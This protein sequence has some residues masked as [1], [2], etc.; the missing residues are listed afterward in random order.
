MS[1]A[2][3]GRAALILKPIPRSRYRR[4]SCLMVRFG[5]WSRVPEWLSGNEGYPVNA[6]RAAP[7][8]DLAVD[9]CF[10]KADHDKAIL[11]AYRIGERTQTAIA[12]AAGPSLSH[13]R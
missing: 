9:A 7:T 4:V 13:I 1:I 8:G 11:M 12:A 10:V 3:G 2:T 6:A 5:S